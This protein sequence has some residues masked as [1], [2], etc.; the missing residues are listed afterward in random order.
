MRYRLY[1]FYL[2]HVYIP[3]IPT[4]LCCTVLINII[5]ILLVIKSKMFSIYGSIPNVTL[6]ITYQTQKVKLYQGTS[7]L[8]K[9]VDWLELVL[10]SA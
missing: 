4:E 8:L 9:M 6:N 10:V 2:A 1:T 3:R 7:Y 5:N